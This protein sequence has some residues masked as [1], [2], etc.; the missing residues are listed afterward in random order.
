MR[1]SLVFTLAA[2]LATPSA[3]PAMPTR[4]MSSPQGEVE[5]HGCFQLRLEPIAGATH[6]WA[7]L[8]AGGESITGCVGSPGVCI[9]PIW[10]RC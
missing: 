2:F 1:S 8:G 7:R 5:P 6:R 10:V 9:A 4:P 3:R